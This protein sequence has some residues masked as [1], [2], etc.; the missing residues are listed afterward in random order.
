MTAPNRRNHCKNIS[1]HL[2]AR[3]GMVIRTHHCCSNRFQYT[4]PHGEE[5][6]RCCRLRH[7]RNFNTPPRTGRNPL[8]LF[9]CDT[10]EFQYT[11]PHGEEYGIFAHSA[12]A[13]DFNTPPRTGRNA[14]IAGA[15][16]KLKISIHPPARGGMIRNSSP[17]L[18]VQISIHLPARGGMPLALH[19]F[20][21]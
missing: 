16:A 2:P 18:F 6:C 9:F 10:D 7:I 21:L 19:L 15:F 14:D 5:L 4:S 13:V 8:A 3:G 12:H 11:S 1:I 17:L 20:I